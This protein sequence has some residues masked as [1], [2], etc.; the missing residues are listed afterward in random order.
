VQVTQNGPPSLYHSPLTRRAFIVHPPTNLPQIVSLPSSL[1][2]SPKTYYSAGPSSRFAIKNSFLT[3]STDNFPSWESFEH[4][5]SRAIT[6]SGHDKAENSKTVIDAHDIGSLDEMWQW[7]TTA[8]SEASSGKDAHIIP[9][10]RNDG[11]G[12]KDASQVSAEE[13]G[14]IRL[15]VLN[16]EVMASTRNS[17]GLTPYAIYNNL[18]N[19][20]GIPRDILTNNH[21]VIISHHLSDADADADGPYLI[22]PVQETAAGTDCRWPWKYKLQIPTTYRCAWVYIPSSRVTVALLLVQ[23]NNFTFP[24]GLVNAL[25]FV[26]PRC[27]PVFLAYGILE[28]SFVQMC[29]RIEAGGKLL[30]PVFA[31]TGYHPFKNLATGNPEK[32]SMD[33]LNRL[34]E[35]CM[36]CC[37]S[38]QANI[39]ELTGFLDVVG[40]LDEENQ[41]FF[42]SLPQDQR[43]T[44]AESRTSVFLKRKLRL[45]RAHIVSLRAGAER[46]CSE[47]Q[48]L[49]QGI[50]NLLARKQQDA[51]HEISQG[52]K[53]IAE[54]SLKDTTSMTGITTITMLFLPATFT[55]VSLGHHCS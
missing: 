45:H 14:S 10:S 28:Y 21:G 8:M 18:L 34:A 50:Q 31:A 15:L 49:A 42:Q 37:A 7:L 40:Y 36:R 11:D 47:G 6:I 2:P 33:E 3:M 16:R 54:A 51:T 22:P 1:F 39:C 48:G 53:A 20:L 17:R 24:R 55:A 4:T 23:N 25:D 9:P 35:I 13:V 27:N 38:A 30:G 12:Q 29:R 19:V 52:S 32:L 43:A 44:S 41:R 46:I 26:A 5:P